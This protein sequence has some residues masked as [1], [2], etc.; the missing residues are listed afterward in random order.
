MNTEQILA[1]IPESLR[2]ITSLSKGAKHC[3]DVVS[4]T[5]DGWGFI[6]LD[7]YPDG[8]VS[9]YATFESVEPK[10]MEHAVKAI[11]DVIERAKEYDDSLWTDT[12]YHKNL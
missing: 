12:H 8:S 4:V 1:M 2:P 5:I 7:C 10:R 6:D 11:I 3:C 9:A